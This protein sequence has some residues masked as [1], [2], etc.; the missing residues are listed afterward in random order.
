MTLAD[1]MGPAVLRSED[2]VADRERLRR[3]LYGDKPLGDHPGLPKKLRACDT[4]QRLL[5]LDTDRARRW[6]AQLREYSAKYFGDRSDAGAQYALDDVKGRLP[7]DR[8]PISR[9]RADIRV[10]LG[11]VYGNSGRGASQ[12]VEARWQAPRQCWGSRDA[13]N[14]T[15]ERLTREETDELAG[16]FRWYPGTD[17]GQ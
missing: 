8:V 1:L 7:R 5:A 4:I 14:K 11:P 15:W 16:E 17:D 9:T 2:R 10:A 6:V 12:L 3:T 13:A